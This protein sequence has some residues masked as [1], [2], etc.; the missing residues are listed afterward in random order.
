MTALVPAAPRRL[1][2][3]ARSVG[4]PHSARLLSLLAARDAAP[5]VAYS[6]RSDLR[7]P[8]WARSGVETQL[9]TYGTEPT[10]YAC[11]SHIATAVSQV[12]WKLYR[13][14][15][16]GADEDRV[17]VTSH[18]ALDLWS[19][20]NS[21]FTPTTQEL[22]ETTEQHLELTGMAYWVVGSVGD[23]PL[24][25]WPVRPDRI[26]PVPV[27]GR[28][29]D[30]WIYRDPDGRDVHFGDD[31]VIALRFPDPVDPFHGLGP[32]RALLTDLDA[33]RFQA[34]WTRNF[35]VNSAQPGGILETEH[36]LSD[37]EFDELRARW[38]EQHSGVSNAHRVAILEAGLKWVPRAYSMKDMEFTALRSVADER[39]MLAFGLS[40]V[41]L[42]QTESVNRATAQTAEYIF[43]KYR[44]TP[45]LER[46]KQVLNGRLLPRFPDGDQLEFDFESPVDGDVELEARARESLASTA[47]IYHELGFEPASIAR[48]LGLP[49]MD[50]TAASGGDGTA[51]LSPREQAEMVQKI[52]LGVGTVVTWQEARAVLVQ[53]GMPLDLTEPQPAPPP[54]VGVPSAGVIEAR[55]R[56]LPACS[57]VH[58]VVPVRPRNA[59][60]PP[61]LDPSDLPDLESLRERLDAILDRLVG[62]W[63]ELEDGVKASLVA[64]V[65]GIAADGSVA[66]LEGL[67]VDPDQLAAAAELLA[68]AMTEMA[69]VAGEDMAAELAAEGFDVDP[70]EPDSKVVRDVAGVVAGLVTAR[71]VGGAVSAAMRANSPS[72]SP[73]EVAGAVEEHLAGL[74][75]ETPRQQLTGALVGSMNEARLET[76]AQGG[77]LVAFYANEI[78]DRAT[79]QSCLSVNG[80][81][82]GNMDE[83]DQVREL[84]PGGAFGG[85]I[86]CEGRERCRGTVTAKRRPGRR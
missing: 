69:A 74:S 54:A 6:R 4:D 10:L 8:M 86:G 22:V 83:L 21:R 3:L 70:V 43:A 65:L 42:G 72:A 80:K 17:E 53:A 66:D 82:L 64:A 46:I 51:S 18:A 57:H 79:C 81:W 29:R 47:K 33:A 59:D 75:T 71:L 60:D 77:P 7:L 24:S 68:D 16:S 61:D 12:Q 56:A 26:E 32:V 13:R 67:A 52:Y 11:V 25:L 48:A 31:E 35:F 44:L 45:R 9:R 41:L 15:L 76:A 14:S 36:N 55:A 38:N 62:D 39:I 85:F 58:G 37:D 5:P 84:Y 20:P 49:E 2:A 23:L 34:E 78:M 27:A 30:G 50:L 73:S 28:F 19:C 40:K 63:A 1:P